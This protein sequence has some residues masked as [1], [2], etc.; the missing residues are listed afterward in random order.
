[1]IKK[2]IAYE[3]ETENPQDKMIRG[4]MTKDNK[5]DNIL[6]VISGE[7]IEELKKKHRTSFWIGANQALDE[8]K[9]SAVRVDEEKMKYNIREIILRSHVGQEIHWANEPKDTDLIVDQLT[10]E[11]C[12]FLSNRGR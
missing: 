4:Q 2:K 3:K 7:G 12:K 6:Y 9:A 1:M 5:K 10:D 11:L 8:V